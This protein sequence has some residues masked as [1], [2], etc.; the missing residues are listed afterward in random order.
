M[1]VCV[2]VLFVVV[3]DSLK[4]RRGQAGKEGQEA[5]LVKDW[6]TTTW[7]LLFFFFFFLFVFSFF[8]FL[9]FLFRLLSWLYWPSSNIFI[10]IFIFCV[11]ESP[12]GR[13]SISHRV[14]RLKLANLL[15]LPHMAHGVVD[16]C[17]RWRAYRFLLLSDYKDST[18]EYKQ[19]PP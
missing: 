8:L 17:W 19:V 14:K 4:E 1:R 15:V 7:S 3:V 2:C 5:R 13:S 11:C 12:F 16:D 9:Y 6:K 18:N 10:S